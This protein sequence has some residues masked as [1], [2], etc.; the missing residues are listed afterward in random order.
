[1]VVYNRVNNENIRIS[2]ELMKVANHY[3]LLSA[4][5]PCTPS[6]TQH[7]AFLWFQRGESGIYMGL[8]THISSM[9]L[10]TH[11]QKGSKR[12]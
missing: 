12:L 10:H 3:D 8:H 9:P 1:M 6:L 11:F 2:P 7:A 4:M 5:D